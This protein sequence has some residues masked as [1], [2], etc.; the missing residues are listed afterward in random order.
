MC[1]QSKLYNKISFGACIFSGDVLHRDM[2]SIELL[3]VAKCFEMGF[4]SERDYRG[5]AVCK[6][7]FQ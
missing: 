5:R 7:L 1:P 6:I 3:F 4:D 2:M